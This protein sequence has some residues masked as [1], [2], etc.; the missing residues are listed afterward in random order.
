MRVVDCSVMPSI[1][2]AERILFVRTVSSAIVTR[3]MAAAVKRLT[4]ADVSSIDS[5][6]TP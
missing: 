6:K 1:V 3:Q 4:S 5:A 2:S